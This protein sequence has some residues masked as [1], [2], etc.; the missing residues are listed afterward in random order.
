MRRRKGAR[1]ARGCCSSSRLVASRVKE[2]T[3]A[4]LPRFVIY[5]GRNIGHRERFNAAGTRERFGRGEGRVAKE[6]EKGRSGGAKSIGN[7]EA[8]KGDE[9]MALF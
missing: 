8:A 9:K 1:N 3:R 4:F 5:R 2:Y 7:D 6:K